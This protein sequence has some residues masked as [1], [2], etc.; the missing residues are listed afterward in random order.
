ME[1]RSEG[2][3]KVHEGMQSISVQVVA[4]SIGFGITK[5]RKGGESSRAS[6]MLAGDASVE[7][8]LGLLE[9]RRAIGWEKKKGRRRRKDQHRQKLE[10][11]MAVYLL[12]PS[13]L[14]DTPSATDICRNML[15]FLL[16]LLYVTIL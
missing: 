2:N 5:R 14:S 1:K 4:R 13:S 6:V 11:T 12:A 8:G 9:R 3:R 10:G 15:R 7:R 16:S